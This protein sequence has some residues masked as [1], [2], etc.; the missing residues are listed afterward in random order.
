MWCL[1]WGAEGVTQSLDSRL[2]QIQVLPLGAAFFPAL[3]VTLHAW[4]EGK[5]TSEAGIVKM[6]CKVLATFELQ[7]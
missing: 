2:T 7:A 5:Y 4:N 6:K 1:D 3:G